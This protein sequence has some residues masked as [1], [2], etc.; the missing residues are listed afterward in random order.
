MNKNRKELLE[1]RLPEL[2]KL[3]SPCKL[4]PRECKVR[5]L[6]GEIG[7]CKIADK[8]KVAAWALHKGEEPP[9]SGAKGSGTIFSSGCT[10]G[11]IFC[12]NFPF[13]QLGNGKEISTKELAETYLKLVNDGAHNINFV[14]PTHVLP[15]L[16]EAWL[17]VEE[18]LRHIPIVY[19]TSGFES[20]EVIKLLD[21]IVDIY[22]PDI[23]Y[24]SNKPAQLLSKADNYVENNR[25]SLK[26]MYRQ[27]GQLKLNDQKLAES[28]MI[29]RH[30]VL[31]NNLSGS[32]DSFEWLKKEL[33]TQIH[34][35]LMS[36]YFP[37]HLAQEY[38]IVNRKITVEEYITALN[39]I[40]ELGF[41]NVWAQDP[42][43]HGGA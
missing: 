33:G 9:I 17:E 21:G 10:L 15:I 37:T 32:K 29:I 8:I 28:G 11:C 41:E 14:T 12:Q 25:A 35:S 24:A 4:C 26:E 3:M 13:S 22:L 36:Q 38:E 42:T 6:D 23:K 16:L 27:V 31:P 40:E 5:R 30:L 39:M 43:Q 7:F 19:N 20:V 34:I 18:Q 2:K 1:K